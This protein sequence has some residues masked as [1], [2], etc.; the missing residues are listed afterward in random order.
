M[1]EAGAAGPE[2][3]VAARKGSQ[4]AKET[5]VGAARGAREA[6]T[7][8]A[9]EPDGSVWIWLGLSSHF[10]KGLSVASQKVKMAS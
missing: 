10:L 7:G 3:S 9:A 6:R 4:T 5:Q 8:L 2:T 1:A